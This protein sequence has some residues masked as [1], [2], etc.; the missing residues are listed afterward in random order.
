L[1][2]FKEIKMAYLQK[3]G[4]FAGRAVNS[5]LGADELIPVQSPTPVCDPGTLLARYERLDAQELQ[6]RAKTFVENLYRID[7]N[8][9]DSLA[10]GAG[11]NSFNPEVQQIMCHIRAI[12]RTLGSKLGVRLA[13]GS[14]MRI[15]TQVLENPP[16]FWTPLNIGLI[17][18][19]ATIAGLVIYKLAK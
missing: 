6:L 1:G 8:V 5:S 14:I 18:G 2:L 7:P 9:V 13:E 11:G 12:F 3:S 16:T 19:G 4:I 17:A 10:S 15:A